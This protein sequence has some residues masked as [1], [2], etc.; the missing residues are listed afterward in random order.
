M[1]A[2]KSNNLTD[3]TEISDSISFPSGTR[4]GTVFEVSA[5]VLENLKG[6]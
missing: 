6:K 3:W 1:G 5:E 2:I 4:H